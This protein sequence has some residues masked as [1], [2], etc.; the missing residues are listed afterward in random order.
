M[1]TVSSKVKL[2]I[3]MRTFE[4]MISGL[5]LK[6]DLLMKIESTICLLKPN[7]TDKEQR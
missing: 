6:K 5:Q 2:K 4:I 1:I 3:L 7:T